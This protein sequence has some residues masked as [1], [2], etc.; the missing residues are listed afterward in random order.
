MR[1]YRSFCEL[2]MSALNTSTDI[3]DL[4]PDLL[5]PSINLFNLSYLDHISISGCS[6]PQSRHG[7][8]RSSAMLL[9]FF[10]IALG[11]C[12]LMPTSCR[13][14]MSWSESCPKSGVFGSSPPLKLVVIWKA[15]TSSRC[16]LKGGKTGKCY[17]A[18]K[19]ST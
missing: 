17:I 2:T 15:G 7:A 8:F 19:S 14:Y 5:E 10:P 11:C 6:F 1:G 3:F 16:G 18:W 9:L 4:N 13:S 12:L